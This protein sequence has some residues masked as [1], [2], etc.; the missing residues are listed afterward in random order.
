MASVVISMQHRPGGHNE[1]PPRD[2]VAHAAALGFDELMA[3]EGALVELRVFPSGQFEL[4]RFNLSEVYQHQ[5]PPTP[6][7]ADGRI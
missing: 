4:R 5:H 7:T 3:H 6:A 1:Q 2:T